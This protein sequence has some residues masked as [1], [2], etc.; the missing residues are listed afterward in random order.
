M[1]AVG[2]QARRGGQA[3]GRVEVREEA[4]EPSYGDFATA[5][6]QKCT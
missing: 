3:F 2:E 6:A 4:F 1:I 5:V